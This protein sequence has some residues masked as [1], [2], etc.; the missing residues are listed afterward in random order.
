MKQLTKIALVIPTAALALTACGSDAEPEPPTATETV[1][2]EVPAEPEVVT[3][4][5]TEEVAP[6]SCLNSTTH[7]DE[8]IEIY[9]EAL[10]LSAD[11]MNAAAFYD[12]AGIA[13]AAEDLE[14][15]LPVLEDELM[16]YYLASEGCKSS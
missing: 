8:L 1:E 15:L 2:V 3:E 10:S 7:A 16:M 4:T 12:E 11:A 5:V 14:A 9:S 13:I 6:E